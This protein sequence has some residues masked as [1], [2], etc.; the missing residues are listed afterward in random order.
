[1]KFELGI[2]IKV[3]KGKVRGLGEGFS[4]TEI[5]KSSIRFRRLCWKEKGSQDQIGAEKEHRG[6]EKD[7]RRAGKGE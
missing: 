5:W 7:R 6:A 1:V 3:R 2:K 4:C